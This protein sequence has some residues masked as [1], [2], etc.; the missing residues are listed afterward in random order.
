LTLS[1]L[2]GSSH[3]L[4]FSPQRPLLLFAR[5]LVGLGCR[6]QR[7]SGGQFAGCVNFASDSQAAVPGRALRMRMQ[8]Q[9]S[10][11]GGGCCVFQRSPI[12]VCAPACLQPGD[13]PDELQDGLKIS[14]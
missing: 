12:D 14:K 11:G 10:L 13:A 4:L 5:L 6:S 1:P 2:H 7:S 9:A 3:E 8:E